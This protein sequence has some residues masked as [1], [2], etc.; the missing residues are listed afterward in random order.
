MVNAEDDYSSTCCLTL[1]HRGRPVAAATCRVFGPL[2]EVPLVATR[3][4]CRRQGHCRVL[5]AALEARLLKLGV[6]YVSLPAAPDAV[7][8]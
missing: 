7:R 8:F 3:E 6:R 2:A 4:A 1:R 5:F